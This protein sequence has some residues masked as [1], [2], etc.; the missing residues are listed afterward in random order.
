MRFVIWMCRKIW[1]VQMHVGTLTSPWKSLLRSQNRWKVAPAHHR[2]KSNFYLNPAEF[3]QLGF[4]K[5]TCPTF[6][7]SIHIFMP[8]PCW[9]GALSG[10]QWPLKCFLPLC[11]IK[12]S[13]AFSRMRTI[14]CGLDILTKHIRCF[15]QI[16]PLAR[17]LRGAREGFQGHPQ[18]WGCVSRLAWSS[19]GG[20]GGSGQGKASFCL[21]FCP[22]WPCINRHVY[23]SFNLVLHLVKL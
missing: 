7:Y 1:R 10:E 22:L 14:W 19:P 20:A 9:M 16:I 2:V 17:K 21:D 12:G 15:G 4:R 6:N 8:L 5:N 3:P 18:V 23:D 13:R 11:N